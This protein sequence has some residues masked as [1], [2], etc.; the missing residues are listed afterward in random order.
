LT[1][2]QRDVLRLIAKG[3]SNKE[4][5][6]LLGISEGTVKLHVTS[7]LRFLKVRNRTEAALLARKRLPLEDESARR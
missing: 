3:K 2:R 1:P 7:I 4:I 5:G 6:R